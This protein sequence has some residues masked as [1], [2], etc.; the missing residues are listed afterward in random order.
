MIEKLSI[1]SLLSI[2]VSITKAEIEEAEENE[3]DEDFDE[4]NVMKLPIAESLDVCMDIIFNYFH[5]KLSVNS[6]TS[7]TQQKL[8]QDALFQYFENH[9]I[10]TH[11][12]KHVHFVFFYIASFRVSFNYK[13]A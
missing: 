3:V 10:K 2:D 6:L 4:E 7:G 13:L 11:N 8:I 12:S 5:S 1:Y 9:V